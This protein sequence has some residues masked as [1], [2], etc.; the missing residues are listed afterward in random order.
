MTKLSLADKG[1]IY[2]PFL[3]SKQTKQTSLLLNHCHKL[4]GVHIGFCADPVGVVSPRHHLCSLEGVASVNTFSAKPMIET[5]FRPPDKRA[6]LKI[7]FH[8]SQNKTYV[9]PTWVLKRSVSMSRLF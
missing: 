3:L 5:L 1:V 6:Y 2:L 8:F 9:V 4:C 7:I